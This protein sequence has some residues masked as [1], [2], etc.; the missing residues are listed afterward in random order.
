MGYVIRQ[1]RRI[2]VTTVNHGLG[3]RKRRKPFEPLWVKLPR[4]WITALKRTKSVHTCQLAHLI[5]WEAYKDKRRT[6]E[7]ILSTAMTGMS[8]ATK[9]RAAVELAELGLIQLKKDGTRASRVM[10]IPHK[11]YNKN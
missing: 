3:S 4:H 11:Y 5:L 10:V 6:G 8:R 1:G 7:V 9:V 2:K